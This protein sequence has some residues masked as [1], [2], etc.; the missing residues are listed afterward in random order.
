VEQEYDFYCYSQVRRKRR[1]KRG[2]GN[3]GYSPTAVR[4]FPEK[5]SVVSLRDSKEKG[6][7]KRRGEILLKARRVRGRSGER[8]LQRGVSTS[9]RALH[10]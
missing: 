10:E 4:G 5:G 2:K 3:G 1:K 9:P 6:E 7:K 8:N